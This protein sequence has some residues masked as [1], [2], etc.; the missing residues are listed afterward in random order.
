MNKDTIKS[1]MKSFI[2]HDNFLPLYDKEEHI[3]PIGRIN[4]MVNYFLDKV[5]IIELIDCDLMSGNEIQQQLKKHQ[6]T[7]LRGENKAV[8]HYFGIF[9]FEKEPSLEKVDIIRLNQG[10][11]I[12]GRNFLKCMIVNVEKQS[13]SRL[14]NT[15]KASWG[16]EDHINNYFNVFKERDRSPLNLEEIIDK[17]K[18]KSILQYKTKVPFITYSLITLN[19]LIFIIM[20][21]YSL[22]SGISYNT[23]L[24]NWGGKENA[25]I[26][27]G[28]YLRFFTPIFL[29]GSFIHVALNCISIYIIGGLAEKIFGNVKYVIIYLLSGI[30]GNI[31]SF[32]FMTNLSIGASGAIMGLSGAILFI[33]IF[34]PKLFNSDL[35]PSIV[36][37]ICINLFNGFTNSGI[38]NFAHIG[39]LIAGFLVAGIL[40]DSKKKRWY[41]NRYAYLILAIIITFSMILWG[42]NNEQNSVIKF[43][44]EL[45]Q[46]DKA[47]KYAYGEKAAKSILQL[48]K[49]KATNIVA[50]EYLADV[51][52]T[53]RKYDECIYYSKKLVNSDPQYA[54]YVLGLVYYNM[55]KFDLSKKELLEAKKLGATYN[56]IDHLLKNMD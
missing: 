47:G 1:L 51:E 42:F 30:L 38:D 48:N 15:R 4:V 5:I 53:L 11:K 20:S 26:L 6:E 24:V 41:F 10:T 29:H 12:M 50:L 3:K 31:F 56:N 8:I 34:K 7:I 18:E 37:L 16:I 33:C 54:H 27:Q 2:E 22:K 44:T 46:Y 23:L 9:V 17:K 35:G 45:Q 19:L 32:A 43:S 14:Y 21:L 40:N 55:K 28:E 49:S 52:M 25:L 39:G 13:V 36:A